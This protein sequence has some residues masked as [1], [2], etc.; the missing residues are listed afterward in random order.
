MAKSIFT[1]E[2]KK[3]LYRMMNNTWQNIG[4]DALQMNEGKD[5]P[6]S[7][8]IELVIDADRLRDAART[9]VEKEIIARFYSLKDYKVMCRIAKNAF[10]FSKYGM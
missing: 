2:E 4:Y 8:V 9:D 3:E 7:H 1:E 10:P 5:L 6:R